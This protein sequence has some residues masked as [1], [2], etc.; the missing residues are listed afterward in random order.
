LQDVGAGRSVNDARVGLAEVVVGTVRSD[1]PVITAPLYAGSTRV[2]GTTT[3]AAGTTIRV[4]LRGVEVA[5]TTSAAGG[6]WTA[7]VP[8]LFV[9][10]R[11]SASA[12]AVSEIESVRSSEVAVSSIGGSVA[13]SDGADNDG[14]GLTDFPADPD[15][16]SASDLDEQHLPACANGVDDDGDGDIDFGVDDGCRSLIDDDESGV[17]EC[18]NGADDDGDGAMDFPADPGCDSATDP[19]ERDIPACENGVDDDGDGAIDYPIDPGCGSAL[20]TDETASLG[21]DGGTIAD[22]GGDASMGADAGALDGSAPPPPDPGGVARPSGCACAAGGTSR[23]SPGAGLA[24]VGLIA[25]VVSRSRR[26]R[27][28]RL[29]S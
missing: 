18:G 17:A 2:T 14:D 20:D 6:A 28:R 8:T 19:S 7:T 16:A 10:E 9:G 3:E 5:S 11:V 27:M 23:G 26:R 12:Q 13:C 29:V 4:Y 25:I 22:A 24:V 1:A 21:G 15:C